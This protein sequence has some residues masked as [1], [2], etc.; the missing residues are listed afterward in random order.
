ML[1]HV[2]VIVFKT[3]VYCINLYFFSVND[4]PPMVCGLE[5]AKKYQ[6]V[7]VASVRIGLLV[8]LNM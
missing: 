5:S 3:C 6:T 4:K 1:C 8:F 2:W 7:V